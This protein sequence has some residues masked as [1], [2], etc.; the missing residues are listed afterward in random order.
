MN[1]LKMKYHNE[2]L[3]IVDSFKV[4]KS[5]K[6]LSRAKTFNSKKA[7]FELEKTSF[8]ITFDYDPGSKNF[9]FKK[10]LSVGQTHKGIQIQ[11]RNSKLA[12]ESLYL[13]S[14]S[15]KITGYADAIHTIGFSKKRP[16]YYQLVIP[17]KKEI[18]FHWS[19]KETWFKSDLNFESANSIIVTIDG[20]IFQVCCVSKKE[21]EYFLIIDSEAKLKYE[22]FSHKTHCI[23]IG[24]GYLTGHYAGGQ[25][26]YFAYTK[27]DK[28]NPKHYRI[29]E[30]RATINS[31]YVPIYSNPYGYIR[32][33]KHAKQYRDKLRP[34]TNAE[35]SSL[36]GR[37]NSSAEF[38]SLLLLILESSVVS[39]IFMPGGFSIALESLSD[40]VAKDSKKE[41]SLIEDKKLAANVRKALRNVLEEYSDLIP[42]ENLK[43]LNGK[44]D[45]F[46]QATNKAKL[47][48]P[49]DL[50][51]IKLN[52]KDLRI[53]DT[54]N[55]LLHGRIPSII[56]D[57][58][59]KSLD[60]KSRDLYY[61]S[62]CLYT[63]LS[64]IILKLTG[65]DNY[66]VNHPKFQERFTQIPLDEGVFR[67]V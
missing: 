60:R 56:D 50:L 28:K 40:Y 10:Q 63:L 24:I 29:A 8:K 46:T 23:K 67:K 14:R 53:L 3:T 31:S 41:L 2:I 12:L 9:D 32:K 48:A 21:G 44:I 42:T 54:R 47:R 59:E 22:D 35:F 49:F 55:D 30:I 16:F 11:L 7:H 62:M 6:F 66:V 36:C 33:D 37:I 43:T 5:G 58:L 65:Y 34:L 17:L 51:N 1:A 13:Q 15:A 4:A 18:K 57:G 45:N 26:Y 20:Q 64:L 52:D 19:I 61:A 39:L 27:K 38:A 25:G